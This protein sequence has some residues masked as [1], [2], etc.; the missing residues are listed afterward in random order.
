MTAYGI[1]YNPTWTTWTPGASNTGPDA[2]FS[3][4]DF[5]N[6][7]FQALWNSG[8]D[9]S[10]N[11]FRDDLGTIGGAGFTLLRLYDWDPTRGWDTTTGVG[12]AH[13]GFLDYAASNGLKVI[14]PVSNYFLSDDTY[15]WYGSNP[16]K[17]YAL[18][19]A[20][21]AIQT[22]LQNFLGSVTDPSTG[23]LHA[24]V[25]SFSV[26][27]EIDINDL[28]GEGS[29][30][31]V[32]PTSR[33]ARV[34]WWLVNLQGQITAGGL[35]QTMLTC[36]ISNA[37]QGDP[38]TT[39]ASYWF[40]CIADGVTGCGTPLPQGTAGCGSTF[41]TSWNG[42]GGLS[43]Y[44]E[45]YYNSVNIYQ[46]GSGLTATLGQYDGWQSNTANNL[47]WPGQQFSVPLL[48]TETGVERA[49]PNNSA[50]Q[51]AQYTAVTQQIATAIQGYLA[52][53]P[54]SLLMG[55]CIYEFNDEIYLKANWGLFIPGDVQYQ[56]ATGTTDVGYA[57]WPTVDYPVDALTAV[58]DSTTGLTL[59]AALS[60]IFS[61]S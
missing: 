58:T 3:D 5:F 50:N 31:A 32:D 21:A 27:N 11:V 23:Q 45:W 4:S 52:N 25:H 17:D 44:P 47:N 28:V 46:T 22:A 7:S 48:L 20:P 37:D 18:Q 51:N 35:G 16:T 43:W 24:A 42:I 54:A 60:G 59:P 6:D 29:S 41:Q 19:G 8:T 33:L 9:S 57:T 30:D 26:G 14:V 55:Y 39:P 10:G 34:L 49:T 40:G 36:P 38:G 56:E 61:A 1:C 13:L 53:D 2:Q 15:A 12:T